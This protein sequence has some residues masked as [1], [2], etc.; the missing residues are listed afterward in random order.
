VIE[1]C[2][3]CTWWKSIED[4]EPGLGIC[5]MLSTFDDDRRPIQLHMGYGR[6]Q[7][8]AVGELFGCKFFEARG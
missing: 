3:D 6:G 4:V 7:I 5:T 8:I 2:R 1:N